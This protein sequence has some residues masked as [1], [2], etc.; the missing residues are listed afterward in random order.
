LHG[1]FARLNQ[2]LSIAITADMKPQKIEAVFEADN[3]RL[4]LVDPQSP[5][6][7]PYGQSL[8]DLLGLFTTAA[9]RDKIVCI[10]HE[11]GTARHHPVGVNAER[12]IADPSGFLH[13]VQGDIQ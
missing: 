6:C 10:S 2:Q 11:H 9:H 12:A 1:R 5:G 13:T 3:A 8:L 4:V 7:Q